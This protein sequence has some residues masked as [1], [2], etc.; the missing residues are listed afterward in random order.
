MA[1]KMKRVIAKER[2]IQ[3]WVAS[4]GSSVPERMAGKMER[5]MAK[6]RKI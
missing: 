1:G 5:V 2:K 4:G 3:Y 6:E